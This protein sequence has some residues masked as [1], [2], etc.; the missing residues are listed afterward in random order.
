M[1]QA[2]IRLVGNTYRDFASNYYAK[3][4]KGK[5]HSWLQVVFSLFNESLD[6]TYSDISS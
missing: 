1:N 2:T 3:E 5:K 6:N 4:L